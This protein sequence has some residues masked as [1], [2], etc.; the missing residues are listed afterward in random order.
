[1]NENEEALIWPFARRRIAI[2][3]ALTATV[4]LAALIACCGGAPIRDRYLLYSVS[5]LEGFNS[6]AT[7]F[8]QAAALVRVLE[9]IGFA[10]PHCS[11]PFSC[12]PVSM[13]DGLLYCRPGRTLTGEM[14]GGT[15]RG[16]AFLMSRRF[17]HTPA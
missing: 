6:A 10:V 3:S 7:T 11:R 1:M 17:A 15:S 9:S 13:S 14:A 8:Q 2:P 16:A 12:N 5:P 4:L